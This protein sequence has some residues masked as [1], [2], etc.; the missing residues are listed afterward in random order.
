M[1][2]LNVCGSIQIR[3]IT[4]NCTAVYNCKWYNMVQLPH[5]KLAYCQLHR[6][7]SIKISE[8]VVSQLHNFKHGLNIQR[9]KCP[10]DIS[11]VAPVQ[12]G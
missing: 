12:F 5:K 7:C 9:P 2:G 1:N 3:F 10:H 11:I 6:G 4:T 8:C